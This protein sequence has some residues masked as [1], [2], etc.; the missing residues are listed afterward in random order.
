VTNAPAS[1]WEVLNERLLL[2][3]AQA[4]DLW[5]TYQREGPGRVDP[6]LFDSVKNESDAIHVL[7]QNLTVT[8]QT[9]EWLGVPFDD[10]RDRMT[11]AVH[12]ICH[13]AHQ[14][15]C[16]PQGLCFITGEAGFIPRRDLHRKFD[17]SLRFL[18]DRCE[19][20]AC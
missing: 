6:G 18:R 15:A 16:T 9:A 11:E 13:L 7:L 1:A 19:S 17:E 2:L 5:E 12:T 14:C 8:D 4:T 20:L 10:W 3:T